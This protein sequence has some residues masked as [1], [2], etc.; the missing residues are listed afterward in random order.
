[1]AANGGANAEVVERVGVGRGSVLGLAGPF[2]GRKL[3]RTRFENL[4]DVVGPY[5]DLPSGR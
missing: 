5:L 4:V 2:R 3:N 1:M